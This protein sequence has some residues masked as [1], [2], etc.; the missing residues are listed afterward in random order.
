VQLQLQFNHVYANKIKRH[1]FCA[2][3]KSET[4]CCCDPSCSELQNVC[5]GSKQKI[6]CRHL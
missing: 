2:R 5:F 4:F 1:A 6:L 3:K